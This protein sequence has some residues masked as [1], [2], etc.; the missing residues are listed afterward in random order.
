MVERVDVLVVGSGV[1]GLAAAIEA[2]ERGASVLIAEASSSPGG[3]SVISGAACCIVDTP[4]QARMGIVDSVELALGDWERLGGADADL[5]WAR[6]YLADSRRD[7]HDWC[8]EL[9]VVWAPPVRKEGNTVARWHAP[10]IGG[11]GIVGALLGRLAG[12]KARLV[13]GAT[14]EAL[15]QNDGCVIGAWLRRGAERIQVDAAAVVI[16]TGGFVNDR[17][18][19]EE[20]RPDLRTLTR[21][22]CGGS[23]TARGAGHRMLSAVGADFSSMANVWIYPTGTP[24]PMDPS[25]HRGVGLRG[26]KSGIW[27]NLDGERF[28]DEDLEGGASGTPALLAQPGQTTW[29]VFDGSQAD[30]ITLLDNIAYSTVDGVQSFWR[31]SGYAVRAQTVEALASAANLPEAAVG[32]SI[33]EFNAAVQAG[34]RDPRTGRNLTGLT[35]IG[36]GGFAAIQ[37]FPMAQKNFGG[38]RTDL[39]GRVAAAGGEHISGLYAA[40]EVAGMAGGSI[41]GVA[42]LEGTMFGPCLYSGRVVGRSLEF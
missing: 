26:V 35:P 7:V 28:H 30:G 36:G 11:R 5:A 10:D 29:S 38:V 16:A 42:G 33:A 9:G 31:E 18:M 39:A 12:T 32:R 19:L 17:P 25:G 22:L 4:E 37:L 34:G 15:R 8:E 14:V 13:T 27:L 2:V 23:A 3:A 41:N 21:Y 1:A 6:T 20:V 40:G 24:D